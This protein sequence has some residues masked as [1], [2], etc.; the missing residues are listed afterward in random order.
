MSVTFSNCHASSEAVSE[1]KSSEKNLFDYGKIEIIPER[2][3]VA[4]LEASAI[5][6]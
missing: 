1:K 5:V 3:T 4:I 2:I 6:R